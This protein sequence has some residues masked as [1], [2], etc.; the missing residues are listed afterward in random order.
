M[1]KIAVIFGTRPEVIKLSPLIND[2]SN[3]NYELFL[4]STGQQEDLNHKALREFKI[5]PDISF[6]LMRPNQSLNTF[7]SSAILALERKLSEERIDY[8]IVHGDTGTALAGAIA[9]YNL[10]IPVAHLE[11]GLRSH[12]LENPFPE[13]MNRKLISQLASLHFSP[14]PVATENLRREGI[15][16]SH[17]REVGNTIVDVVQGIIRKYSEDLESTKLVGEFRKYEKNILFTIH[18][19]ENHKNMPILVDTLEELAQVNPSF[20][21]WVPVHPN[22]NVKSH[23]TKLD[24]LYPN[25]HILEPLDYLDFIS[26]IM[27]CSLVIT[28]SGGVQEEATVL[29]RYCLVLRETTERPELLASGWGELV[30]FTKSEILERVYEQLVKGEISNSKKSP[31]GD[32]HTLERIRKVLTEL[33]KE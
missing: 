16:N 27:H 2:A 20:G 17:I 28:D 25:L 30:K 18:R 11:A 21:I 29:K 13:E 5:K 4:I 22:P 14:T 33:A 15:P 9:A 6:G 3:S 19:R 12:D 26:A 23:L 31:F 24:N 1:K 8:V 7:L 10:R 32:G